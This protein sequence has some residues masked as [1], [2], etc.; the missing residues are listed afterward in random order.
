[1][2]TAEA[3]EVA[4]RVLP[5]LETPTTFDTKEFK[6]LRRRAASDMQASCY[7]GGH[8]FDPHTASTGSPELHLCQSAITCP[9]RHG[10]DLMTVWCCGLGELEEIVRRPA[11]GSVVDWT[12]YDYVQLDTDGSVMV[13]MRN[14]SVFARELASATGSHRTYS[15]DALRRGQQHPA[16]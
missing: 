13:F 8:Y 15:C 6:H 12:Y 5:L 14:R 1:M 16:S 4:G 2:R 11:N 10:R 3:R 9:V 7:Y